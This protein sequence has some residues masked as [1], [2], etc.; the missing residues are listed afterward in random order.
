MEAPTHR[1]IY[2]KI[3][4][5][6]LKELFDE[7]LTRQ[8][9]TIV[10]KSYGVFGYPNESLDK[11]ALEQLLKRDAIIKAR[12]RA[13]KKLRGSYEG[14]KLKIWRNVYRTVMREAEKGN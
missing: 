14:S 7:V 3:C 9:K 10:G 5:E 6:F 2:R 8:E 11:I 12:N 4:I 1:I 13:L